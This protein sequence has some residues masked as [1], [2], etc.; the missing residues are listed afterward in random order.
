MHCAHKKEAN[1]TKK[2]F[3]LSKYSILFVRIISTRKVILHASQS[4]IKLF[5]SRVDQKSG[6]FLRDK[7]SKTLQ[8]KCTVM[9]LLT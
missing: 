1:S 4:L 6:Q 3:Q 8:R 9:F 5:P 2:S 7:Q